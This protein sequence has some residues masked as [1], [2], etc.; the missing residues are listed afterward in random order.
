MSRT[1][2]EVL[3]QEIDKSITNLQESL[4]AGAASDYA[5]YQ[6]MCGVIKGLLTARLYVND[7]KQNMENSDE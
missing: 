5:Q 2:F 1:V 6:N 3:N 7:L 4:G